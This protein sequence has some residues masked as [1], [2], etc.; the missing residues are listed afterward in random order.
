MNANDVRH[1]LVG[2]HKQLRSR[3]EG[4]RLALAQTPATER[5]RAFRNALAQLADMFCAQRLRQEEL[6]PGIFPVLDGWGRTRAD[7]LGEEYR[8][9]YDALLEASTSPDR[10]VALADAN[11][12]FDRIEDHMDRSERML[13]AEKA[14]SNNEVRHEARPSPNRRRPLERSAPRR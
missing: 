6:W 10:E 4:A 11:A 14:R 3:L 13:R 7:S 1:E 12:L 2:Q 9:I 5:A 8:E